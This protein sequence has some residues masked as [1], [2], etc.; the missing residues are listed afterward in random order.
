MQNDIGAK[1]V[2]TLVFLSLLTILP[3]YA[4]NAE[5]KYEKYGTTES[6]NVNENQPIPTGEWI[7][8]VV[9]ERGIISG[10]ILTAS[11]GSN[12]STYVYEGVESNKIKVSCADYMLI[13]KSFLTIEEQVKATKKPFAT[14]LLDKDKQTI[15]EVT[16]QQK[17]LITFID[18]ENRITVKKLFKNDIKIPASGK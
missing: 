4:E 6:V 10:G 14:L 18:K 16:E 5:E 13:D 17:L 9:K 12:T 11:D 8:S 2:L 7:A 1:I 3:I 15:F